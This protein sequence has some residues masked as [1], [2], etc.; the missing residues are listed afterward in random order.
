MK[1]MIENNGYVM[2]NILGHYANNIFGQLSL[3]KVVFQKGN[4]YRKL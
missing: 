4:C 3:Y 2:A 1:K